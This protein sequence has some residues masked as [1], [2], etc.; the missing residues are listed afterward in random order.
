MKIWF[1]TYREAHLASVLLGDAAYAHR[2]VLYVSKS[3]GLTRE[4]IAARLDV[5]VNHVTS[6]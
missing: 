1:D 3:L 4:Q 2:N 5:P 6:W